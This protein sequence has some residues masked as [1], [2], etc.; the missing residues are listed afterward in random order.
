MGEK[1]LNLVN[2]AFIDSQNLHM[3]IDELGWKLDYKKLRIY[4]KEHYAV[5]KS[6]YVYGI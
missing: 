6:I 1:N 4:L 3:S 5:K 2:Y